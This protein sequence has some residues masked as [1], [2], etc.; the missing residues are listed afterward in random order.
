MNQTSIRN[1][2]KSEKKHFIFVI[3]AFTKG[4]AQRNLELV[5]PEMIELG[6]QIDLI[7]LQNSAEELN[8][9]KLQAFG[10]QIHRIVARNMYDVTGFF[11]FLRV[12][13]KKNSVIVANLFWSQIWSALV[14]HPA[15]FQKLFWVEH[16]TYF[17]RTNSHWF[18]YKLLSRRAISVL[19]VSAE[20]ADFLQKR[21]KIRVQLVNNAA[22]S[23][24]SRGEF[25]VD[26]F[27][28]LFVGRLVDQKN[29]ILALEAFKHAI[30]SGTIA[31][32]S[33]LNVI[34]DGPLRSEMETYVN[35]NNLDGKIKFL[36]FLEPEE[37]SKIMSVSQTLIM[38]SHH[39]GSPLVRL[40]A[41]VHGMTIVTTRTAG[42][43]GILTAGLTDDLLPGIFV[44]D[45]NM[46]SLAKN[47]AKSVEFSVWSEESVGARLT[48]GRKFS[49]PEVAKNYYFLDQ[50]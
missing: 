2:L 41:L 13:R 39:E 8:L 34:G 42:I 4:G 15:R 46:I 3:D 27:R 44:S 25:Q 38:T 16:N 5:L 49:P 7:L 9:K 40:E 10:V 26:Y 23:V 32:D 14:A 47:L 21:V 1:Y 29:P 35:N 20:I 6:A 19:A 33:K 36:G 22:L 50:N 18:F 45:S 17:N 12:T 30:D 37:V 43:K 24:H 31:E 11:R 28:F 48:N